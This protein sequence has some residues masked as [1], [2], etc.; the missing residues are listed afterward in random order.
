MTHSPAF[1]LPP[2]VL[3]PEP[4]ASGHGTARQGWRRL[5]GAAGFLLLGFGGWQLGAAGYIHAK[6]WLAQVLLSHAWAETMADHARG[7]EPAG[8]LER[9]WPWADTGPVARLRV[10]ELGVDETVLAGAS[11]RTLAFGPGHLDQT[12][13]PGE[14]GHSVISGHRD[15]HFAFLADLAPDMKLEVQRADGSWRSYQVRDSAVLDSRTARLSL[16]A[17]RPAL[18]LVTCWP[19]DAIDPGGPLRYAVYATEDEDYMP[20][21]P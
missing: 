13:M 3:R 10:P 12:A 7:G 14:A 19:F 6:A 15:T 16:A 5:A 9:P 4:M 18:T 1:L 8:G 2:A 17:D 11:G 21:Q 20:P